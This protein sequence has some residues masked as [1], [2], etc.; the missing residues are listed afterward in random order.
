MFWTSWSATRVICL[1]NLWNSPS[2][3]VKQC[4]TSFLI[5]ETLKGLG[6]HYSR[7]NQRITLSLCSLVETSEYYYKIL[8]R[9]IFHGGILS[10]AFFFF[11]TYKISCF[12]IE[13]IF[14]C[15][16]LHPTTPIL[17]WGSMRTNYVKK[18]FWLPCKTWIKARLTTHV[19]QKLWL[20]GGVI[21]EHCIVDLT[22]T[23]FA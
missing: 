14:K 2:Q 23:T 15:L 11:K 21:M 13:G 19:V 5:T 6:S 18:C 16:E 12:T 22:K 4:T 1:P 7:W 8:K 9:P 17:E 3:F 10:T 20:G